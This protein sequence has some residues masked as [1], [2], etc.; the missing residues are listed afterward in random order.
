MLTETSNTRMY[1][2]Q[3][4]QQAV[5]KRWKLC[6]G[7]VSE[8][9]KEGISFFVT[10]VYSRSYNYSGFLLCSWKTNKIKSIWDM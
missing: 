10:Y 1:T 2:V 3:A 4:Q 9:K 6:E 5:I 8:G 7:G